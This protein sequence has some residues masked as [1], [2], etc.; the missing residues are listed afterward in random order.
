MKKGLLPKGEI[1]KNSKGA[2][3]LSTN[4][5]EIYIKGTGKDKYATNTDQK[6]GLVVVFYN[7]LKQN[8]NSDKTPF[9]KDNMTSLL[10]DLTSLGDDIYKG[11]DPSAGKQVKIY[12]ERF[13]KDSPSSKSAQSVLND[14][15]S[16]SL[17]MFENYPEGEVMRGEIFNNIKARAAT[18]TN[19]KADK[20]NPGDIFF[21]SR[22]YY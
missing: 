21:K 5:Y 16:S 15:L 18:L 19:L 17:R 13:D 7:A 3:Y 9:N 20:I 8:W 14:N 1:K 12:F 4:G 6:E 22:I 10:S 2:Y 11:L